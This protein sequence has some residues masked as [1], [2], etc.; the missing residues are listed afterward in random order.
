MQREL[1]KIEA[2]EEAMQ[3]IQTI[4]VRKYCKTVVAAIITVTL[5]AIPASA[6]QSPLARRRHR[7]RMH[8]NEST[9]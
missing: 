9:Q 6:T 2:R 7:S 8:A 3:Q 1:A 4:Q 5:V